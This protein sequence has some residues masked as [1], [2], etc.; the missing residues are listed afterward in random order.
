MEYIH[1]PSEEVSRRGTIEADKIYL[2]N[3]EYLII[4]Y[5]LATGDFIVRET[6]K[7]AIH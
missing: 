5:E 4:S 3:K 6:G 7:N 1:I 2:D